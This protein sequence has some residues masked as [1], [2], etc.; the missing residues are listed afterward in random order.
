MTADT[1]P[2]RDFIRRE[3]LYEPD[4]ALDERTVIFPDLIDSLGI[5]E[6]VDFL[7][8]HYGV[9]IQDDELL[10]DNFATLGAMAALLARKT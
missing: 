5:M 7:E 4:A 1:G 8:E 10:A 3:L 6:V 2:I 9:E